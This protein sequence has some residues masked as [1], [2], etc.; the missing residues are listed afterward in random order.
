LV[1]SRWSP[2]NLAGDCSQNDR[3]QYR[4]DVETNA[5]EEIGAVHR[6]GRFTN[7][8]AEEFKK[9]ADTVQQI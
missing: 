6:K 7:D 9:N 4:P 8:Q 5:V 1:I 3:S 2:Q